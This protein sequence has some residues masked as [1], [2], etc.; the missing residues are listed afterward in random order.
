MPST[1]AISAIEKGSLKTV[2]LTSGESIRD[3]AF[4]RCISLT[5]IIIPESVTSIGRYAFGYC[6]SLTSVIIGSSVTRIGVGAFN[7]CGSLTSITIPSR[8][9]SIGGYAFQGCH[10]LTS[11][12]LPYG[13]TTIDDS[14]FSS[15]SSLTSVTIPHSV[16][17]IG[18]SAFDDCKSL[19]NIVLPNNLE[20]IGDYTFRLSDTDS[21]TISQ[22]IIPKKVTEIGSNAFMGRSKITKI[23]VHNYMNSITGAPWGASNAKVLWLMMNDDLKLYIPDTSLD[24]GSYE[25]YYRYINNYMFSIQDIYLGKLDIFPENFKINNRTILGR[26]IKSVLEPK[27]ASGKVALSTYMCGAPE[28]GSSGTLHLWN[29]DSTISEVT[30]ASTSDNYP[31]IWYRRIY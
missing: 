17:S 22:I 12:T 28:E 13:I 8:V 14:T 30:L 6:D 29:L 31:Q 11:I 20:S 7:N 21:S 27:D 18:D 1:L 23:I 3:N 2:V 16:T 19:T 4:N 9:T 10:N 15:C 26:V 25:I 24:A 5:D